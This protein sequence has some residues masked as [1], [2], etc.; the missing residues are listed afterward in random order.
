M[1]IAVAI[2]LTAV[3]VHGQSLPDRISQLPPQNTREALPNTSVPVC[4]IQLENGQV[5]DLRQLCGKKPLNPAP[6]RLVPR[7][8]ARPDPDDDD[9]ETTPTSTSS[10]QTVPSSRSPT[11]QPPQAIPTRPT[12]QPSAGSLTGVPGR[13][14]NVQPSPIASPSSSP[15]VPNPSSTPNPLAI[16]E[17]DGAR[18]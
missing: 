14:T 1:L 18:D 16:P 4:Y 5:R 13:S 9:D 11:S 3:M 7:S 15:T 6:S 10:P 2:P 12:P 8:T 17:A